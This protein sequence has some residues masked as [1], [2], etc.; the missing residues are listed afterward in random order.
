MLKITI[1]SI[2]LYDEVKNEFFPSKAQELC[3]EHSLVSLS[4]WE[5]RWCKPFLTKDKKTHEE[6]IDYMR[7]MTIT[8]NV[9]D[10]IYENA[11]D[12]N[13]L[14]AHNYI[15]AEMTATK[16]SPREQGVI[17]REIITAEIIYY[18]MVHFN[19]PFE[20]Q[21]WHLNRLL[22]LVNVCSLKNSPP[23][24]MSK[25]EVLRRNAALNAARR[26]SLNSGG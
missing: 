14:D 20:C 2:E 5:S 11:S 9:D 3:L 6:T 4:K 13:I 12:D 25:S 18:W 23:K 15:K 10:K 19:I 17:N 21:K 16:F 8:Q 26:S 7:C 24:K 1:P 22:A